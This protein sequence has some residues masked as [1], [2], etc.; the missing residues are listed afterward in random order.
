MNKMMVAVAVC[1]IGSV[2]TNVMADPVELSD[3]QLA[4]VTARTAMTPEARD[5]IE[6]ALATSIYNSTLQFVP[7]MIAEQI[8]RVK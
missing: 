2:S 5:A 6:R 1:I 3:G 8:R 4:Q 7:S